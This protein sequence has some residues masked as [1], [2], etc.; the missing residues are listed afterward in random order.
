MA[1]LPLV[2]IYALAFIFIRTNQKTLGFDSDI[3][4]MPLFRHAAYIATEPPV[5]DLPQTGKKV[6]SRWAVLPWPGSGGTVTWNA[7]NGGAG[8]GRSTPH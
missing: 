3:I 4:R 7:V 8:Q 2:N 6:F 5:E 1:Y